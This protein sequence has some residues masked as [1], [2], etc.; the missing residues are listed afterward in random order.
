MEIQKKQ[1]LV[2]GGGLCTTAPRRASR[3]TIQSSFAPPG[4]NPGTTR[5]SVVTRLSNAP[6]AQ[7]AS[8]SKPGWG[9]I[10]QQTADGIKGALASL[11]K[12][13]RR[14]SGGSS[15]GPGL[16]SVGALSLSSDNAG[17]PGSQ[18]LGKNDLSYL[19]SL[20]EKIEADVGAMKSDMGSMRT[21]MRSVK[22]DLADLKSQPSAFHNVRAVPDEEP[23]PLLLRSIC[24]DE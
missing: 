23:P 5:G 22:A 16:S 15:S 18:P 3:Q 4:S 17:S 24:E 21:E 7:D 12:S 14:S 6:K 9:L 2:P 10:R 11:V 19:G 1:S 13:Q 8:K 20:L